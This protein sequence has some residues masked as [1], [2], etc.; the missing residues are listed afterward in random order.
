MFA[1]ADLEDRTTAE[2]AGMLGIEE[3]T[4]RVTLFKA[5]RAIRS[6]LLLQQPRLV[7]EYRP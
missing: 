1:L 2:I 3:S 4:V 5:R 7:E 6:K